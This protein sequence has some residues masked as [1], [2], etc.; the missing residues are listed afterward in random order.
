MPVGSRVGPW[1]EIFDGQNFGMC[2]KTSAPVWGRG[3][4][5]RLMQRNMTT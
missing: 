2:G 5:S 3:L 1:I 4:K